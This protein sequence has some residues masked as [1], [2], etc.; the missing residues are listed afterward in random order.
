MN[1]F[2]DLLDLAQ[3]NLIEEH[4]EEK[5]PSNSIEHKELLGA[6]DVI[7]YKKSVLAKKIISKIE[8]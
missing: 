7:A 8:E 4:V 5:V 1:E 3:L 6:L 2:Q